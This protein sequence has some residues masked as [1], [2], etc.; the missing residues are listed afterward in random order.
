MIKLSK[1]ITLCLLIL[2]LVFYGSQITLA[3]TFTAGQ[4]AYTPW[5]ADYYPTGKGQLHQGYRPDELS[6]LAKYDLYTAQDGLATI[7]EQT[8]RPMTNTQFWYGYCHAWAAASILME[9][10]R[11]S[12]YDEE[13]NLT[14]NVGD[15]KGYLL[16]AGYVPRGKMQGKGFA[17]TRVYQ[18]LNLSDISPSILEYWLDHYIGKYKQA[19]VMERSNGPE[20]NPSAYQVWNHPVFKYQITKEKVETPAGWKKYATVKVWF[21]A[22]FLT[23]PDAIGTRK[24]FKSYRYVLEDTNNDN[25]VDRNYWIGSSIEDHPDYLWF[26]TG[27]FVGNSPGQ[28]SASYAN[29]YLSFDTILAILSEVRVASSRPVAV[30]S[31]GWTDTTKFAKNAKFLGKVQCGGK[32]K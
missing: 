13:T 15:L 18:D 8:N 22:E 17:K 5:S 29:P 3:E 10:P 32:A 1:I 27:F 12:H 31:S 19:F 6:P 4:S 24:L 21:S 20:E 7:W 11:F 16:A 2:V 28:S 30:Y 26:P 25:K 14:F 23:N 9:E